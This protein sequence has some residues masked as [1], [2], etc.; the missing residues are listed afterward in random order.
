MPRS[1]GTVLCCIVCSMFWP[2]LPLSLLLRL[3]CENGIALMCATLCAQL[4]SR[5]V[6]V[7]Q[8]S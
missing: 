3:S 5:V 7:V 8:D 6:E 2:C 1:K 4:S